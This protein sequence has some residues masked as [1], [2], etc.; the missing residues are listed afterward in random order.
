MTDNELLDRRIEQLV[1]D[2]VQ[3]EMTRQRCEY[4]ARAE[5]AEMAQ[6]A[7]SRAGKAP[8]ATGVRFDQTSDETLEQHIQVVR[9]T[10]ESISGL[11]EA[12]LLESLSRAQARAG[13]LARDLQQLH[14]AHCELKSRHQTQSNTLQRKCKQLQESMTQGARLVNERDQ[15]RRELQAERGAHDNL[16]AAYN[17]LAKAT[18]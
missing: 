9:D 16:R 5:R 15:A 17:E 13:A 14:S 2:T 1:V 12:V 10:G 6:V 11:T 3:R 8:V 4:K 7:E 18:A